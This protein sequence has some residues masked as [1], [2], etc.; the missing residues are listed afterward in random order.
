MVLVA[1]VLWIL[2][3]REITDNQTETSAVGN[4]PQPPAAF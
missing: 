1:G 4:L 3:V 2:V